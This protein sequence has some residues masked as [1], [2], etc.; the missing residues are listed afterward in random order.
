M[1]QFSVGGACEGRWSCGVSFSFSGPRLSS[2][3]RGLLPRSTCRRWPWLQVCDCMHITQSA[4]RVPCMRAAAALAHDAHSAFVGMGRRGTAY[5]L[6]WSRGCLDVSAAYAC[7]SLYILCVNYCVRTRV[8]L[9]AVLK[10]VCVCA[11]PIATHRR[12]MQLYF[13]LYFC[14]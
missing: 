5:R 10:H 7:V 4:Q 3:T 12:V 14:R 1:R 13:C 6:A 11:N 9:H 8:L 2:A